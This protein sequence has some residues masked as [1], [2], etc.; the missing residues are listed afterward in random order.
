[1]RPRDENGC[2]HTPENS[3]LLQL[4][5]LRHPDFPSGEMIWILLS[6]LT[7]HL[8]VLQEPGLSVS[9]LPG[10]LESQ[11]LYPHS[12]PHTTPV[13]KGLRTGNSGRV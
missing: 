12:D 4:H 11:S 6:T 1:M 9:Q 7:F 5:T 3:I 2:S 13:H 8:R 10:F